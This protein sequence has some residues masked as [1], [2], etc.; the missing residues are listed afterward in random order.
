MTTED[1]EQL[2]E[3]LQKRFENNMHR[4][5]GIVW[6]EVQAKL[7]ASPEKLRSLF[8]M[9]QT[10]GEP[11]VVRLERDGDYVF[12]DCSKETPKGRRSICYDR[13]ALEARKKHKPENSAID[14]ANEMGIELLTE[15]QYFALQKLESFDLKS[16]SWLKTPDDVRRLGGA[17]F[18]D[19]RYGRVFIYH[20][21]ADSY[22]S[23]RGFRGLLKI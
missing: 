7:E 16:S 9:E 12:C 3:T 6:E 2:L 18:G 5:E 10:G 20:N 1:Q 23:V 4:H 19:C 11:D 21:G 17:I 22:Y 13:E 15:E 8:E 14:M